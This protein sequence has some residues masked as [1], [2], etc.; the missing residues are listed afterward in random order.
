M[1]NWMRKENKTIE[2][3]LKVELTKYGLKLKFGFKTSFFL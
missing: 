3:R 2:F 1:K